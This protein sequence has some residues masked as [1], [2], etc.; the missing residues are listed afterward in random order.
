M[1][2]GGWHGGAVTGGYLG[3]Q[4]PN[5]IPPSAYGCHLP[6]GKGGFKDRTRKAREAMTAIILALHTPICLIKI[7]QALQKPY[8]R[9]FAKHVYFIFA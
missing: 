1:P 4:K 5:C 3:L 8:F 7:K 9:A 6:L 2:K